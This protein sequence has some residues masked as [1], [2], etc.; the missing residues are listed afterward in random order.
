MHTFITKTHQEECVKAIQRL[1]Q[2]PSVLNEGENGTPFGQAI[3]DVLEDTLKLTEELGFKTYLDP[4]GYYGY[5]EIGEGKEIFAILCHLDVVPAGVLDEWKTN[6]FEAVIDKNVIYGRGTQDDKG[7]SMAA[8]FAVKALMDN[9]ISFNKRIRF[10]FGTDEETLWRGLNRYTSIEEEATMG[11]A[12]DSTFPLIYAE[13]GLLQ[14]KLVG[15]GD[16]NLSIEVGEAYNIV[17][18]KARYEGELKEKLIAALHK[19]QFDFQEDDG[20]IVL[21]KSMHAKD[22]PKATNAI[23]RLAIALSECVD[24]PTLQFIAQSIGED[25]TGTHLFGKCLEDE[26]S[27]VLSFNVAGLTINDEKTE[28]RLDIRIPVLVNKEQLVDELTQKAS[29]FGLNYEEF[30]YLA[31]LYVPKDS[32][33]IQQLMAVYHEKTGDTTPAKSSGGATYAR[34]M[35]NCVAYGAAFPYT[36]ET[37]H[38]ENESMPLKDLFDAMDIYAEAIYRLASTHER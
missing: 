14:A 10:I 36:P 26:P 19:H 16:S 6:P 12:P 34:T 32:E 33:L 3:Q 27:G 9:G 24:N 25:A 2:F 8:L 18:G 20:I 15:K 22:A 30:D 23:V 7:P 28:I 17:P 31:P 13:K 11:F 37:E 29:V 35:K 21:G 1:V 4:K 38:K 5:A